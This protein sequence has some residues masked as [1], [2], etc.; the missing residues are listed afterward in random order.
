MTT[1]SSRRRRNSKPTKPHPDYPLTANGNGQWSKKIRGR[2]YYFG[3]WDDPDGALARYLDVKDD[4]L[5]GR[6][7]RPADALTVVDLVNRYLTVKD[8]LV[9]SGEQTRRNWNDYKRTCSHVVECFGRNRAVE[10]LA[11]G[12]F[13]TLRADLAKTR[14]PV[15]LG[16]EIQRTRSI[17]KYAY[18][19]GLIESSLK[20]G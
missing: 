6:P 19:T 18:D 17:F 14:G 3:S 16:N 1:H 7:P 5:A 20:K 4:L 2:V 13:E 11:P 9:A 15:A 12:D 10:T 8:N